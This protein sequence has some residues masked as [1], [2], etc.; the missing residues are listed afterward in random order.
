M[1]AYC[2]LV[3]C[4]PVG[5]QAG[6]SAEVQTEEWVDKPPVSQSHDDAIAWE[7][8]CGGTPGLWLTLVLL[9]LLL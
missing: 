4:V 9:L 1:A 7:G 3:L 6:A 5:P 8:F 2:E